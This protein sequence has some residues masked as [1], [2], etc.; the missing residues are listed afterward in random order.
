MKFTN[1]VMILNYLFLEM[2][3]FKF[4]QMSLRGV[5]TRKKINLRVN[6]LG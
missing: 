3:Q 1:A 2:N 5:K 4:N 6:R